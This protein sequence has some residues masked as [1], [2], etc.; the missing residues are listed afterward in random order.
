MKKSQNINVE[1]QLF[2]FPN[3]K[4]MHQQMHPSF[5]FRFETQEGK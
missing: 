2:A 4:K 5:T 1:Q 3:R